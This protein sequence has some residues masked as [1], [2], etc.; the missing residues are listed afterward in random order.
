[1]LVLEWD[2]VYTQQV[3]IPAEYSPIARGRKVEGATRGRQG[4]REPL[5]M[6]YCPVLKYLKIR[7]TKPSK[8]EV[9]LNYLI[10]S[11]GLFLPPPNGRVTRGRDPARCPICTNAEDPIGDDRMLNLGSVR[12]GSPRFIKIKEPYVVMICGPVNVDIEIT[13]IWTEVV[14]GSSDVL[15]GFG[16]VPNC[17]P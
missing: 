5:L 7:K 1:M 17:V 11:F 16:S 13:N 8:R 10:P 4:F 6:N 14:G 12:H 15:V 3:L 9:R 2:G